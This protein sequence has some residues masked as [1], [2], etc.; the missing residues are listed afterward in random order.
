MC[1]EMLPCPHT[2]KE[3]FVVATAFD[4]RGTRHA[5]HAMLSSVSCAPSAAPDA[6]TAHAEA[7]ATAASAA[8]RAGARGA[9]RSAMLERL[10]AEARDSRAA[11]CVMLRVR[12]E[13]DQFRIQLRVVELS[14]RGRA[15]STGAGAEPRASDE[16]E[17]SRAG[18]EA[19]SHATARKRARAPERE[20]SQAEKAAAPAAFSA[21]SLIHI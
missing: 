4:P 3:H 2:G 7:R 10:A 6:A 5:R 9:E 15:L 14:R 18:P 11:I 1:I 21:L 20:A 17:R 16:A 12:K 8:A 13:D 19:A